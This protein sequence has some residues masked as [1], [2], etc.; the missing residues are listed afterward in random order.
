MFTCRECGITNTDEFFTT[1]TWCKKCS[2]E[3]SKIWK[4]NNKDSVNKTKIKN[5]IKN[6]VVPF[7]KNK[8]CGL[9]LGVHV[10]EKVLSRVFNNVERMPCINPGYDFI[11]NKNKKIDVKSGC[12][13]KRSINTSRSLAWSF[14]IRRNK[15]ADYFLILAF[16]NRQELKPMYM[17]FIPANLINNLKTA[18]ITE[19]TL[20]KWANFELNIDDTIK[21]C[22]VLKVGSTI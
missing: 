7:N 4:R 8:S 22:D 17:W 14:D 9:Y 2:N 6:G 20:D 16:S 15:I 19:K 5:N 11:C 3:Y 10:A 12:I 13:M 1:N 18:T 21:C